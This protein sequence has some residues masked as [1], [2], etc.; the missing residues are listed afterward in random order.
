MTNGI[1]ESSCLVI[2]GCGG[3]ARSLAD[4]AI[5]V[6]YQSL[7]FVDRNARVN[8]YIFGFAVI[9]EFDRQSNDFTSAIAASGNCATQL[10]HFNDIDN[11]GLDIVSIVSPLASVSPM[12]K[13]GKGVFIGHHAHVGPN[14]LIGDGVIVNTGAI[15]EHDCRVGDYCHISVNATLCGGVTVGK[16]S[17][18]GAGATVIDGATL[19]DDVIVGAGA[20]VV[21]PLQNAGVY[22]GIPAREIHKD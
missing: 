15:V 21:T 1:S 12:S 17:M 3:Q 4:V 14:S 18:V 22:V 11:Y 6:G 9:K 19:V 13:I 7:L 5:S 10:R 16:R 20:T 2:F 8:E